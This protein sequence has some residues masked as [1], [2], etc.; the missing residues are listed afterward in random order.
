MVFDSNE[1]DDDRSKN[2]KIW[3]N[4]LKALGESL[5]VKSEKNEI[6]KCWRS[7]SAKQWKWTSMKF[8]DSLFYRLQK[9]ELQNKRRVLS[10]EVS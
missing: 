10:I 8:G 5:Q 2:S 7:R 3:S 4:L 1:F 9:I 6:L